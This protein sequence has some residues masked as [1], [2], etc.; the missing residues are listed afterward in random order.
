MNSFVTSQS[1]QALRL[2]TIDGL[3]RQRAVQSPTQIA[4][5]FLG[6]EGEEQAS[7][8][9]KELDRQ[10]RV[11]A[12]YLRML[13]VAGKR[14]LLLYPPGLDYI[15]AFFGCL[16]AGAVAVPAYPPRPNQSM[17]RLQSIIAD[18][19]PSIALTVATILA[20]ADAMF[21]Q[22][23]EL[24]QLRLLATDR[25]G[26]DLSGLWREPAGVNS[27]TLAFLQYTS[28]STSKPRGVMVSHGNLL[29][30]QRLIQ[31]SFGQTEQSVVVGW[32]PLYHDMGLIGNVLQPLFVGA[33][34]VLMSPFTF[35]QNPFRW[36]EAISLYRATTT[37]G[38]NFA[39]DLCVRKINDEQRASLDL[40]SWTVAFNG[41]EPVRA[42][43]LESFASAFESCGF[44]REAFHPCYGLAEST[45]LVSTGRVHGESIGRSFDAELLRE[46][47]AVEQSDSDERAATLVGCGAPS[48]G[49]VLIIDPATFEPCADGAVG[50]V[51]VSGE[52]VAHGYWGRAE[53]TE[54]TFNG[55][56]AGAADGPFLRTGD[57]GFIHEGELFI[58]GRLKDLII[59][60]GL[61]HYPQDIE[62]TV[63]ASTNGLRSGCGAAFSIEADA[64]ERLVVVQEADPRRLKDATVA[65]TDIRQAVTLQHEVQPY[66]VLLLRAGTIP[67]TSSGKIQRHECRARFLAGELDVVAEWRETETVEA[68]RV[69]EPPRTADEI[70]EWLVAQLKSKTGADIDV[71]QTMV[72]YGLDS[73][74]SVEL[75][76]AVETTL[77]VTM[78]AMTFVTD[79]SIARLAAELALQ[80]GAPVA[81]AATPVESELEVGHPLS[82]GQQT[83]WFLHRLAPENPAY[84]VSIPL[85]VSG[86]LNVRALRHAFLALVERHASL[87]TTFGEIEGEPVQRIH[88]QLD[89]FFEEQDATTWDEQAVKAYLVQE[90]HRPFDL[91]S[92]PLLRVHLLRRG[93]EQHVMLLVFH[94][95]AVDFW[96]LA[97]LTQE[98]GELYA[99]EKRGAAPDLA[100]PSARYADYVHWQR[101]MLASPRGEQL[102]AYWEEQ[103]SGEPPALDLPGD[104]PRPAEQSF[105]GESELVLIDE[106]MTRGLRELSRSRGA[107]LYMTLL[108]A[109]Q[110]LLYRYTG[111]QDFFVGSPTAGRGRAEWA[112]L[113]GYFVNPVAL[114]ARFVED[115]TF[116]RHLED[117]RHTVLAALEHQE[118]PFAHLVE[119]LNLGR[120]LSRPQL[121]QVMF[122]MQ[123]AHLLGQEGLAMLALTGETDTHVAMADLRLE[124]LSL[125]EQIAQFDLTLSVAPVGGGLA[126]SLQYNADLFRRERITRMLDHYL[127]LLKEVVADPS[128]RIS[129]LD[130]L[131]EAERERQLVEWNQTRA[132]YPV[133][134][135]TRLFEEQAKKNPSAL[136]IACGAERLT[137]DDLNRRANRLARRLRALGVGPEVAAAI[138][139]DRS[140]EMVVAQ[141]AVLKAGGFYVSLDPSYPS[142]RLAYML[143]DSQ[144]HVLLTRQLLVATLPDCAAPVIEVDDETAI[145]AESD[146]D[147]D[148]EVSH[149]NLAYMIYTSGS[150]GLPKGV[151]VRHGGLVNLSTWHQQA[152]G[153]TSGDKATQ[154]TS[155]AFDA[156]VWELWPYLTAGASVHLPE[157]SIRASA[158][159]LWKWLVSESITICFLPT[160]LAEAVLD[161]G[162][163]TSEQLSLRALLTGGDKLQH[164]PAEPLPFV[165]VN[166]YGP[167][168]NTVVATRARVTP[169]PDSTIAPPIGSPIANT[170]AYIL[171]RDLQVMPVGVAGELYIGGDGLAR[172]YHR[173]SALTAERFVPHPFSNVPGARLYKTGDLTRYLPD[174]RIEFLGRLDHQVKI[175]GF[176][177]ELGEIEAMLR[178]HTSV[179]DVVVLAH[180]DV[181]T[182]K[183]LVAYVVEQ[184]S[185]AAGELREY[186]KDK[187]PEY[188]IPSQFVTLAEFPLTQN[189]KVDRAAL[190]APT[191]VV[192]ASNRG[193]EASDLNPVEEVVAGIWR[194]TL[195]VADVGPDDN[196]FELGGHSL[197][198]TQVISRVREY[199]RVELPLRSL[200]ETPTVAGLAAQ[201]ETA[202]RS[203]QETP[204]LPP[205]VS[206]LRD[207]ALPLSSAQQRLWFLDRLDPN[208][209][210]YNIPAA[211]HM[212]GPL[213]IA[214]LRRSLNE[215]VRRH[216]ALRTTFAVQ[217]GQ[218]VQVI[219]PVLELELPLIDLGDGRTRERLV[220]DEVQTPFDLAAGPLVRAKLLRL[221][222]EEHVL[223]LTLHHIVADGWSMGVLIRE[224]KA[225]YEAYV[226]DRESPLPELTIQY[227]DFAQWQKQL[228]DSDLLSGELNYWR[229][230]LTPPPPVI[231]LLAG[232]RPTAQTYNGS[233]ETLTLPVDM[234]DSLKALSFGEGVTLFMTL[235][236]GFKVLLQR[237]TGQT[238]I[239]VGTPVAGRNNVDTE[240][241]IGFFANTLVLRT[242]LSGD[243]TFRELLKRVRETA[244]GAYLHQNVPFERLVEELHPVRDLSHTPLFQVMMALQNAH[245]ETLELAGLSLTLQDVPATTAKFDL[246]MFCEESEDGLKF[247]LEYN[248]DLFER[249]TI[250]RL[251][252]H[253]QNVLAGVLAAPD[254]RISSLRLMG[255]AEQKQVLQTWN[256]TA[257]DYAGPELIHALFE[258]QAEETPNAVAVRAGQQTVTYSELNER[259][260]QLA[261]HLLALGVGP[262]VLVG[263]LLERSVEMIVALLG[264]LKAGGAYVPLDPQYP[265]Q[266]MSFIVEDTRAPVL[267]TSEALHGRLQ[268]H[269]AR[270]VLLDH[271]H[272]EIERLSAANP[273]A[274][275]LP[276]N[277]AYVIYTSGS[278]GVPKG[279][280][281][282]HASTATFLN[283]SLETFT[284]EQLRGVLA[285]TSICFDLSIFELF[286]PL[287]CGGTVILAENALQLPALKSAAEVTLINTVPSAIAELARQHAIPRGVKTVNLAGEAL[288]Q[289]LVD[290]IFASAASVE[291][292]WNLYGPSE[293]TTYSTCT[294]MRRDG[295]AVSIGRPIARTEAYILDPYMQ[296]AIVGVTGELYLSGRGLARGYLNRP[297]QTAERFLPH[298]F[299]VEPGAR[300]YRTGDL[301]RYLPDGN[302]EYLGRLDN[303]V[304][305]RG[306]R[307]ELGEIEAALAAHASVEKAVVVARDEQG[308]K[309]IIAYLV[310]CSGEPPAIEEL[311]IHLRER[312]PV[313][314]M[315]SAF[316]VLDALPLSPNGKVNRLALPAPDADRRDVAGV[317]IAPRNATEEALA[318]IW[319]EVLTRGQIGVNDNFF[320]LGGHSL[321]ATQAMTKLTQHFGVELP[322]RAIFESPTVAELAV[323]VEAAQEV[324]AEK[325]TQVLTIQPFPREAFR[326][327][328]F[329][330]HDFEVPEILKKTNR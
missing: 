53:A 158:P 256:N 162:V 73:L 229:E 43:T 283:W 322:L 198:A 4:Y 171:D 273:G 303:Q 60:R 189:G 71:N 147:F 266:R 308:G 169:D 325:P 179:R 176:R 61:N 1:E 130:I 18:A 170:Q 77:G 68:E 98:L 298:P 26:D 282:A 16:Y 15:A 93:E 83:I 310:G 122:A 156:S 274:S 82:Y 236:A 183:R 272:E 148:S 19:R 188:M 102:R 135:V 208:S 110:V 50:E 97:V 234:K 89:P 265:S 215:I 311:R 190:P 81:D 144:A 121:F 323:A 231:E 59:I 247:T 103:L 84:N 131:T 64:E 178:R 319:G 202:M 306:F 38:P 11:I 153:V 127:T 309:S 14:V 187:L 225:L 65:L 118:Y 327:R 155:P 243:P 226:E 316:V 324:A 267:L 114:R 48:E 58:T 295:P 90:S 70:E 281:I 228:V 163:S 268:E 167:T 46:N 253:W 285:A 175:S 255:P 200:F 221:A 233:I 181:N 106:E 304:K 76:H 105:R 264:V 312:L 13:N 104:S 244:L 55:Y 196:F 66:A 37:G 152:Y 261:H 159:D 209:A 301:A 5:T 262:E 123:R 94:H 277:L 313:Y 151:E 41:A 101:E 25:I 213:S 74:A 119:T 40:S 69:A 108:A 21:E 95:I 174:G 126:A 91:E 120:D 145:A 7:L 22:S 219:A 51:W 165:L 112:R 54:Q 320:D 47:R 177:I 154:L 164:V 280:A 278:T 191:E 270:V 205:L 136:A 27:D 138:C 85:R 291:Q 212:Q 318:E 330:R 242:D 250:N 116:A 92:G 271:D 211:V 269:R 276:E 185:V 317:Y 220:A 287:S 128:R 39:Y 45:L 254:A 141:L 263:V 203:G 100:L 248:T 193:Q 184:G 143:E 259:A 201:V 99:A 328:A 80:A 210:L 292:V 28:G 246:L 44:R 204:S 195:K 182:R 113:V 293:D 146:E 62:S 31:E 240:S 142:E 111:Q 279:V 180:G 32:L 8:T 186:L 192:P 237:Y 168:E 57:L 157:E 214:A 78:P 216:E 296:P 160:P 232:T 96:S 238:D 30:N 199:F 222:E 161:T 17:H 3:L 251:L 294:S 284:P 258:R 20:R 75:V 257:R 10:A 223:L 115:Q 34:C 297:A 288:P 33:R 12:A 140:A 72:S 260:N 133:D 29:H 6:S 134:C 206:V 239:A 290:E 149:E 86:P 124:A 129:S 224:M 35:L 56:T 218:P 67:K 321:L 42:R 139:M 23:P 300:L 52:S 305:I 137:Y 227:A 36:L 87:R 289:S 207:R 299:S 245:A 24:K 166:H 252:Q 286:V 315:P 107:T 88:Q 173:R 302:I 230:Q 125:P 249:A 275:V 241:L 197:L 150:T 217:D 132:D 235:L 63:E 49:K 194:V 79:V 172:G 314:M 2:L 9:Y 109:F 117:V 329:S 326:A 307:I